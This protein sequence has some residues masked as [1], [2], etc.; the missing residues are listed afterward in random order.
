[1]ATYV[2]GPL[3]VLNPPFSKYLLA[4]CGTADNSIV[5]EDAAME[6]YNAR[7]EEYSDES[8]GFYY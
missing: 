4:K 7:V 6:A 5:F 3:L 2:I 8:T 1:M